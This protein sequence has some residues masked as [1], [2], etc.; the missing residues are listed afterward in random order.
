MQLVSLSA[1][2]PAFDGARVCFRALW[3]DLKEVRDYPGFEGPYA[4][5]IAPS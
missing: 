4:D 5:G 1:Y 2:I 3:R